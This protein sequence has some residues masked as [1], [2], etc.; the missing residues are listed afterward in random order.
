M[1]EFMVPTG[2]IIKEYL[3]E[4]G[5]S[6]KELAWRIAVSEKHISN[7][8]NG[9]ARL[10]EDMALRLEHVMPDVSAGYW[11]NHEAKYREYL[12]REEERHR[13]EGLDLEDIAL[14]FHFSEVFKD[15]DMT[16]VEQA[17]EMLD[18]LGVASF[19]C[20]YASVPQAE[21]ADLMASGDAEAAVVWLSLCKDEADD[22]RDDM[23]AAFS[24][25]KLA[26]V[27]KTMRSIP[28]DIKLDDMAAQ[29]R[30]LLHAAGVV[31][32]VEEPLGSCRVQSVLVP[33]AEHPAIYVS[34]GLESAA[35]A[36]DAIVQEAELLTKGSMPKKMHITL[37]MPLSSPRP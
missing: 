14:R 28:T 16:L 9:K 34:S 33:D 21:D 8:L 18:L 4:R 24:R 20:W 30:E 32:A 17:D 1:A 11:L 13:I 37:E 27:L 12:A 23:E 10:T 22:Q 25:R 6:Q 2:R 7:M 35:A 3:D 36:R 19:N 15:T 29:C 26:S 31:L 5:I